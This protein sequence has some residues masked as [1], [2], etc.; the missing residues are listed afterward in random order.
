MPIFIKNSGTENNIKCHTWNNMGYQ[1][2]YPY[3]KF[4]WTHAVT[5]TRADG[6]T[7]GIWAKNANGTSTVSK[8]SYSG[9]RPLVNEVKN[10]SGTVTGYRYVG[11]SMNYGEK[12][13]I[14]WIR[15]KVNADDGF[16]TNNPHYLQMICH[17]GNLT[18]PTEVT[19]WE[20]RWKTSVM[21]TTD[22]SQLLEGT[23]VTVNVQIPDHTLIN[24]YDYIW[25]VN[26]NNSTSTRQH[27]WVDGQT[28]T[29]IAGYIND[30]YFGYTNSDMWA[31]FSTSGKFT[32]FDAALD[33]SWNHRVTNKD[34]KGAS[35]GGVSSTIQGYYQP[36][37]API[38]V[39]GNYCSWANIYY[40]DSTEHTYSYRASADGTKTTKTLKDYSMTA[41]LPLVAI[42]K[43]QTVEWNYEFTN[44]T[45]GRKI[46]L[47]PGAFSGTSTQ[48]DGSEVKTFDASEQT[49]T[50]KYTAER[51]DMLFIKWTS[52]QTLNTANST[53]MKITTPD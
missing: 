9:R 1:R 47:Q 30:K 2:D 42:E 53:S 19:A 44:A 52:G 18:T 22:S 8:S 43:D 51:D 16:S 39:T 46:Y 23:N 28:K 14:N 37:T 4:I 17:S 3:V 13:E 49:G 48:F 10:S 38:A 21:A 34:V 7:Y 25:E 5:Y 15:D 41:G 36:M 29:F 35:G 11:Y 24:K 12:W 31:K 50:I 40:N 27:F 6:S 45:D 33:G 20:S 26:A 32:Y